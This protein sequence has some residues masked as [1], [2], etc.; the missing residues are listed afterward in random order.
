MGA[1]VLLP[2]L[3]LPPVRAVAEEALIAEFLLL[4]AEFLLPAEF[5]LAGDGEVFRLFAF[6][7]R[8]EPALVLGRGTSRPAFDAIEAPPPGTVNTTS[9][10]FE[11]CSTRAVAPG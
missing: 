9:S 5:L 7:F 8:F 6:E 2:K 3:E 1:P 4:A 11:R 10:R